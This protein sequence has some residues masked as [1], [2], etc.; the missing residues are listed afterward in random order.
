[1]RSRRRMWQTRPTQ[2][3]IAIGRFNRPTRRARS[4][5]RGWSRTRASSPGA[6]TWRSFTMPRSIT[7]SRSP[8]K[9]LADLFAATTGSDADW[10]VKLIDVYPDDAPASPQQANSPETPSTPPQRASS[11][12]SPIASNAGYQLMVA[13]EIFRGRYLHGFRQ[14]APLTPGAVNE[15]RWSLHGVDHTFLKGH[16]IMVE[17]PSELVSAL[18]PQSADLCAEH[19]GR[20]EERVSNRRQ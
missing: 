11:P 17:V 7:T 1:M 13:D 3:P 12:A 20:A 18:R 9:L 19:H 14:P 8:A 16:K 15:F 4:G 5:P 2:F 10:I 6:R